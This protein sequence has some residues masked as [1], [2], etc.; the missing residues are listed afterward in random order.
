[1]ESSERSGRG[2]TLNAMSTTIRVGD[3]RANRQ[4]RGILS[5][6]TSALP[7]NVVISSATLVFKKQGIVGSDP[8]GT[9]GGLVGDILRHTISLR[10]VFLQLSDFQAASSLRA[11]ISAFSEQPGGWYSTDLSETA[12]SFINKRGHTLVRLRFARDDDG[13]ADADCMSI[14]SGNAATAN[15]PALEIRY[16]AP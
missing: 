1:L 2:G 15:R 12:R 3:D 10:S 13:D 9:H 11:G 8:S 7:D 14:Y 6:D 16:E 5:F 4:Y